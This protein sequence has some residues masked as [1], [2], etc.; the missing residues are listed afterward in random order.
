MWYKNVGT[1]FLH[2]VTIHM[3]DKQ[4]WTEM[5]FLIQHFL[6]TCWLICT[7]KSTS[8]PPHHIGTNVTQNSLLLPSSDC[9]HR[10]YSLRPLK[11]KFH[12]DQFLVTSS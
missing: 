2:F 7:N 5:P 12:W 3:F 1:S 6:V 10:R 9:D 4:R 8:T 11:A